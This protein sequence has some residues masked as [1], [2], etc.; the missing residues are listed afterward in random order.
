MST[1]I[2]R[3][4][5]R[6]F[7]ERH[8]NVQGDLRSGRPSVVNEDV[9]R[10]VQEKIR[11]NRRFTITPLSLHFPQISLSLLHEIVSDKLKFR[12]LCARWVPKMLTEEHKLKR[13]VSMLDFLTRYSEEGENFLSRVVT[14]NETCVLHEAPKSKQQSMECR[15]TSSPTKTKFKQTTLA[16][17]IMCTMF[18]DRK[19]VLL[20]GFL[21]E[22]FTISA[23]IYCDTLQKLRRAIQNKRRGMLS[24]GVVIIHANTR[25]H[26]ATQNLITTVGWEQFDD[27][28]RQPRLSAN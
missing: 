2:V 8:E 28:P 15:H 20:V 7:N 25:P 23:G 17:K 9:V 19:G 11:E 5:V 13:Q 1:S 27:P 24:Q 21:P 6:L 3:R 10:T 22:G 12:K 4:W 26:T 16:R 14:G 18:W